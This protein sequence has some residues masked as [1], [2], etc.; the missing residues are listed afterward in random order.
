MNY[1]IRML[2]RLRDRN[3]TADKLTKATNYL[4]IGLDFFL[5]TALAWYPYFPR[6]GDTIGCL[7]TA[8]IYE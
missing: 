5:L 1:T 8:K 3:I 4:L 2:V 6:E 7:T